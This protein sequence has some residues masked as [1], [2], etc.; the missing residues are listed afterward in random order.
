M[1]FRD[2]ARP[3]AVSGV[4][5]ARIE[6]DVVI[7]ALGPIVFGREQAIDI[8][9]EFPARAP[10]RTAP[11]ARAEANWLV[12]DGSSGGFGGAVVPC[13]ATFSEPR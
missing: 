2:G 12:C 9:V 3:V 6:D 4:D 13:T 10:G 8:R 7:A 1:R 11:F 5:G